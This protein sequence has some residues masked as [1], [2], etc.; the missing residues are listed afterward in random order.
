MWICVYQD[1]ITSEHETQE[2]A[3]DASP[4]LIYTFHRGPIAMHK[5][6]KILGRYPEAEYKRLRRERVRILEKFHKIKGEE[7]GKLEMFWWTAYSQFWWDHRNIRG[8]A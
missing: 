7:T 6:V 5:V 1:G 8:N 4:T 2:E 3:F